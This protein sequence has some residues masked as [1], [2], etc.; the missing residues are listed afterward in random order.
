MQL[1][2]R[3]RRANRRPP[4]SGVSEL[5]GGATQDPG[6]QRS[7]GKEP[8]VWSGCLKKA[9]WV[10]AGAGKSLNW[11]QWLLPEGPTT[12]R[13]NCHWSETK[14]IKKPMRSKQERAS[15]FLLLLLCSVS[16]VPPL[17]EPNR[18][19]DMFIE[20]QREGLKLRDSSLISIY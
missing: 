1:R 19:P 5:K 14:R 11:N 4:G 20:F 2:L 13:V 7:E 8:T 18:E 10:S 9:H 12:A 6:D 15:P 3:L 17:A 16:L